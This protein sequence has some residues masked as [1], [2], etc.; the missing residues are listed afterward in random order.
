[1]KE[2]RFFSFPNVI[3]AIGILL[4][5]GSIARAEKQKK[6][7]L[8]V[9]QK[10][11]IT[12]EQLRDWVDKTNEIDKPTIKYII[13]SVHIYEPN[14][15]YDANKNDPCR[16]NVWGL[17][18]NPFLKDT[19]D[20]SSSNK[21]EQRVI[22][23]PGDGN[24]IFIKDSTPAHEFNHLEGLDH[25]DTD[26]NNKMYPDNQYDSNGVLHSCHR[27]GT[28]L[29][30]EQRETIKNCN[31][32]F[33]QNVMDNSRGGEKYDDICDV[34]F[35]FIDLEWAQFWM[36]RLYGQYM[37]HLTAT[38][39]SLSFFDFSEIGFYIESD[40]DPATGEPPEGLDYYLAFQPQ[41]GEIIF[42]RYEYG[43]IPLPPAGITYEITHHYPDSNLPPIPVGVKLDIPLASFMSLSGSFAFKAT[44]TNYVERD[45]V[46]NV[47][48]LRY[49]YP[50]IPITGDLNL[51]NR[52]DFM[53]IEFMAEEWINTGS[54]R[55]DIYP[56]YGNGNVNFSDFAVIA[57]NWMS[58]V[59]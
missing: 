55:A 23:V 12:E 54:S 24:T 48:L 21:S 50:M 20:V 41:T 2:Q 37:V 38:V 31:Y 47:G 29:S 15:P 56:S 8:H 14:T 6:V 36:E 27:T 40:N 59:P 4:A 49:Y 10:S 3:L 43:W 16:V 33:A 11:G 58:G 44:A 39:S 22:L 51:D 46:P 45:L 57:G 26:P 52:V 42:Q 53:D 28:Q 30:S 19:P 34:S 9:V 35:Y 32:S 13:D 18:K 25:N 17:K 1:M 7:E 5:A